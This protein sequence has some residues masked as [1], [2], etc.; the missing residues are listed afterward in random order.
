M[1][2]AMYG[3]VSQV[4]PLLRGDIGFMV[5]GT[6]FAIISAGGLIVYLLVARLLRIGETDVAFRSF[7]KFK[8]KWPK[9]NG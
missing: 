9:L 4:L 7:D 5:V 6:K 8:A 3:L 1:G 2:V